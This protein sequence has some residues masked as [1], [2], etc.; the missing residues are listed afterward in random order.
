MKDLFGNETFGQVIKIHGA[1][2]AE[3]LH[4]QLIAAYGIKVG[5]KCKSC[6]FLKRFGQGRKTWSKCEKATLEGHLATDWRVAWQAC[7]KF[8]TEK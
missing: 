3:N 8:E 5:V 7:G 2:K 6:I 1:R 4:M